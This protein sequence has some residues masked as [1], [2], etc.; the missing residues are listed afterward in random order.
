M[1]VRNVHHVICQIL[2]KKEEEEL[3]VTNAFQVFSRKYKT[4]PN[5]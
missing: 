5:S 1:E 4:L 3:K 2:S